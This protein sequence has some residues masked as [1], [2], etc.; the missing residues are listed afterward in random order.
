[1]PKRLIEEHKPNRQDIYCN[2]LERHSQESDNFWNRIIARVETWIHHFETE[3]KWQSMQWKHTLSSS[4]KNI[5]VVTVCW[6]VLVDSV[7]GFQRPILEYYMKRGTTAVSV[8]YC[9]MLRN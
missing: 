3:T 8:N 1:V 4:S 7:L 2:L 9:D 5:Q 6:K